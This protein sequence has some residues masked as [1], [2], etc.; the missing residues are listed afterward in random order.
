[1][2]IQ[3]P[4]R[5]IPG[6][7]AI[8]A[9]LLIAIGPQCLFRVCETMM[10]CHWTAQAEIGVGA[11]I[12]ALGV[13]MIFF[14]NSEI[15]LGLVIGILLSGVLALLIPHVLIGGCSAVTMQCR[16]IAFPAITVISILLIAGSVFY[17]ARLARK[18]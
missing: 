7:V 17:A 15:R 12:A 8:V 10:R 3:N 11:V 5:I 6:A 16:K 9:G 4:F 1:M 13:A 18:K 14:T 2:K